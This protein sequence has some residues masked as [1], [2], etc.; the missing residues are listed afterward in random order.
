MDL[1]RVVLTGASGFLG[2]HLLSVM[3]D[4]YRI[5][6]LARRSQRRVRAPVHPNITWH[7]ADIGVRAPL[8]KVFDRV[9][10]EGGADVLIH[11]AA[12]YDFSGENH[13]EYWRTNVDGLRNVLDLSRRLD[14]QQ[15]IF[16]SSVAACRFPPPGGSIDEESPP[17]GEPVYAVT[18][19][20]G[21]EMLREYAADFPSAIVR[22]GALFSDWCEYPPLF[23]FLGTWLSQGWVRR[24]LAGRGASAIPYL[25]IRDG[26]SFFLR[27]LERYPGLDPGEALVASTDGCTAH[28]EL[29]AAATEAFYGSP[30]RPIRMPKP[31]CG[32]GLHLRDIAGRAFGDRPFERP[33][34]A[35]YID[36][37]L[38]VDASHTRQRIGWQPNPRLDVLRRMPFLVENLRSDPVEWARR[39][40]AAMKTARMGLHLRMHQLLENHELEIVEAS[41]VRMQDPRDRETFPRYQEIEPEELRWAVQQVFRNLKNSIRARDKSLFRAYCRDLAERRFNLGFRCEELCAALTMQMDLVQKILKSDPQSQ[42]LEEAIRDSIVMTLRIGIDEVLDVYED[43]GGKLLTGEACL[44]EEPAAEP[45]AR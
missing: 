30:L 37:K 3:K 20:I 31:F 13:P 27:L 4:R 2:R 32:L 43:L 1:P 44:E 19:R 12:Y 29:F 7:Q 33:W 42:G 11:L 15:F 41:V 8:E 36:Q 5:H 38:R 18:K 34:M 16:A 24:V 40:Q 28:A 35:K 21:E 9:A 22:L 26:M 17:D 14:L 6:A 39:N 23:I 45:V 25:H 10:A